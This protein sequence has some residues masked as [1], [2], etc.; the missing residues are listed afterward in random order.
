MRGL[1]L[2]LGLKLGL[3]V[4]AIGFTSHVGNKAYEARIRLPPTSPVLTTA[5]HNDIS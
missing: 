4:R 5:Q 3:G 2:G 1:G